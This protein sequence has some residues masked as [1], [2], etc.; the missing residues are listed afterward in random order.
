M[1]IEKSAL[2]AIIVIIIAKKDFFSYLSSSIVGGF[3]KSVF[4]LFGLAC[5]IY[6]FITKLRLSYTVYMLI[7]WLAVA[8]TCSAN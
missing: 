1:R 7:T 5:I 6:A 2:I 8:S 3:K 4:G